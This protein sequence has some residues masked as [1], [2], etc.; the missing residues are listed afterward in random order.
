MRIVNYFEH[1]GKDGILSQLK[2]GAD[3]WRAI[4]FLLSL[5]EDGTFH[6]HLGNGGLY[7]LLEESNG[8]GAEKTGSKEE[9]AA[10]LSF[11]DK[12]EIDAPELKPWIGFVFTFPKWRGRHLAGKL[13]DY[14]CSTL[15][16]KLYPE[17]QSVFVSTDETGLYE[18]YGFTYIGQ[19]QNVWGDK[20]RIYS[21]QFSFISEN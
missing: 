13:I 4:P 11:C 9:L 2:N 6:E 3:Y 7:L 12:D 21:R 19:M 18:K 1:D 20:S 17:E 15:A 16:P 14:C 5:L 10:F 8:N